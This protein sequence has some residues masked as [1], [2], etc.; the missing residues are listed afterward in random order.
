MILKCIKSEEQVSTIN[1]S[2]AREH[3]LQINWNF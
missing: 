1:K 2:F 3:K